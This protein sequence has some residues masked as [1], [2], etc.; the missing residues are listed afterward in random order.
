MVRHRP[1]PALRGQLRRV[2]GF[3]EHAEAPV[4]RREFPS[5]GVTLIF[6]LDSEIRIGSRRGEGTYGS[7]VAGLH[8]I[9]VDTEH[10]GVYR[11]VQ[12]DLSPLG[13]YQL[14]GVPMR[15]HRHRGRAGG[16]G[17]AGLAPAR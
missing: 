15:A 3:I 14:F 2:T 9:P 11:C 7:F 5:T 17:S 13:G 10:P 12:V 1:H 4:Y 8:E 16:A 6:G